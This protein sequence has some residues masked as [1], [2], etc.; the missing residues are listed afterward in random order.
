M[1][2]L[3][4]R[5]AAAPLSGPGRCWQS[6]PD[7]HR[8]CTPQYL[9]LRAAPRCQ[10][11]DSWNLGVPKAPRNRDF[12][13]PRQ[14][15]PTP[16][17]PPKSGMIPPGGHPGST[18]PATAKPKPIRFTAPYSPPTASPPGVP[19]STPSPSSSA[20]FSAR[21]PTTPTATPPPSWSPG[22][23]VAQSPGRR[24]VWPGPLRRVATWPRSLTDGAG[25]SRYLPKHPLPP[26]SV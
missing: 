19:T 10:S 13:Q 11:T 20:P 6:V 9:A 1:F 7:G 22:G 23:T 18:P 14:Q 4:Q 5:L 8:C 25:Y 16:H 26:A 17:T 12:P 24:P 3:F 21:I 2:H 15:H